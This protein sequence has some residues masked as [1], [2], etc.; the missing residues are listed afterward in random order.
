MFLHESAEYAGFS[1]QKRPLSKFNT[2][3]TH[4]GTAS[5]FMSDNNQSPLRKIF[6]TE[7]QAMLEFQSMLIFFGASIAIVLGVHFSRPLKATNPFGS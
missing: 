2:A 6:H 1:G 4:F 7:N 3:G 5:E